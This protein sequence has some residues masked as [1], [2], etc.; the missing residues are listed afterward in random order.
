MLPG[1]LLTLG[2]RMDLSLSRRSASRCCVGYWLTSTLSYVVGL[3]LTLAANI[4]GLTF[5]GAQ[6]QPALL[7]LVPCTVGAVVALSLA[8]SECNQ[9]WHGTLLDLPTP[10]T[11][12]SRGGGEAQASCCCD[13][14][15][16]YDAH[17]DEPE[18]KQ[19]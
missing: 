13:E 4:Y 9:V 8:R 16:E 11:H 12:P 3:C 15:Y 5:N 7:Y 10:E 1:L 17:T 2:R 14:Y 18:D 19:L 6:G